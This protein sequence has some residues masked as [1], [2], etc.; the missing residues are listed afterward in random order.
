MKRIDEIFFFFLMRFKLFFAGKMQVLN[1]QWYRNF[2][3][4]EGR[5]GR[6]VFLEVLNLHIDKL[7]HFANHKYQSFMFISV[8]YIFIRTNCYAWLKLL[9]NDNAVFCFYLR[10]LCTE[11]SAGCFH[12]MIWQ[13]FLLSTKNQN[14]IWACMDLYS[15][16]KLLRTF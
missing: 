13:H 12:L 3:K 10:P 14:S 4:T 16:S 6:I 1:T 2:A 11:N 8:S 5:K 9:Q 15:E 7:L